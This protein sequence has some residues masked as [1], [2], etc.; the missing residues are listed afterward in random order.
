MASEGPYGHKGALTQGRK[1]M[2]SPPG[3][4]QT[5]DKPQPRLPPLLGAGVA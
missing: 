5:A 3:P 4:A 1:I 2:T